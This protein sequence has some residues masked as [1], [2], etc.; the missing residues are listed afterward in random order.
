GLIEIEAEDLTTV[1]LEERLPVASYFLELGECARLYSGD[2]DPSDHSRTSSRKN[3]ASQPRRPTWF[4]QFRINSPNADRPRRPARDAT[5]DSEAETRMIP[6]SFLTNPR[7]SAASLACEG[8]QCITRV[9][10][11]ESLSRGRGHA[12]IPMPSPCPCPGATTIAILLA[13]RSGFR[14]RAGGTVR[15]TPGSPARHRP[16]SSPGRAPRHCRRQW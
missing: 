15:G 8:L 1:F 6:Q 5:D 16:A 11:A 2:P 4:R 7:T 3:A 13:R 14:N 10:P 9:L 12:T